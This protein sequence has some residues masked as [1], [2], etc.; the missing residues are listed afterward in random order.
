MGSEMCIRDSIRVFPHGTSTPEN[1][2]RSVFQQLV[3]YFSRDGNVF[4]AVKDYLYAVG[5]TEADEFL[6]IRQP[7]HMLIGETDDLSQGWPKSLNVESMHLR[8]DPT[9][10]QWMMMQQGD[11]Y[12]V[13]VSAGEKIQAFFD[14]PVLLPGDF[15]PRHPSAIGG[16]PAEDPDRMLL[17]PFDSGIGGGNQG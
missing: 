9:P 11:Q 2:D 16:I 10:L 17:D 8:I 7:V 13:G 15:S 5:V 4:V 1:Q 12:R 6:R 14:G 3:G